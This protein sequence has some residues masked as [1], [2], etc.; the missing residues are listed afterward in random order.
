LALHSI[1]RGKHA[2]AFCVLMLLPACAMVDPPEQ[3]ALAIK[4]EEVAPVTPR[5]PR[6]SLHASYY[7]RELAG[8]RTASGEKFNPAG[9]TAAHR[10]LPFGTRL[11]VINPQNGR[12]VIVRINDRGPFVRSRGIDVSLGAAQMLGFVG[13]G[14][15]RLEIEEL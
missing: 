14:T 10:T 1:L 2:F 9:M 5:K 11:R 4:V 7:G 8:R 12:S 3:Q 13:Q 6:Q 15:A